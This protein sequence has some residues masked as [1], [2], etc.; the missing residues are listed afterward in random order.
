MA[1]SESFSSVLHPPEILKSK[2]QALSLVNNF[3]SKDNNDSN[4]QG[5][6][7]LQLVY[8]SYTIRLLWIRLHKICFTMI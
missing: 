6:F 5:N 8:L 2:Y 1:E 3:C 7:V 4:S